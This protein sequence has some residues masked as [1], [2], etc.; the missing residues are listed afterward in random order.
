MRRIRNLFGN[1]ATDF[2][3]FLHQIVFGLE[4][5]C[6]INDNKIDDERDD[7]R[8]DDDDKDDDDRDDDKDDD[9]DNDN[10]ED[11]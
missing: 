7:D 3:K 9:Y 4:A 8:D 10:D 1:D 2:P 5:P 11:D 6:C